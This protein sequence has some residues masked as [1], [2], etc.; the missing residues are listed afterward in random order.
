MVRLLPFMLLAAAAPAVAVSLGP[1]EKSGITDG[2][3][4][5]FYL[6][7]AN[8]YPTAERFVVEAVGVADETAQPRVTMFPRDTVLGRG[9]RRQ[10]LVIVN[11]L[12]PGERFAFRVCA[13]RSPKPQETIHARVCS[14]LAAR[15][16]APR[17]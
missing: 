13:M 3:G 16:L 15:R 17:A 8:P 6:T 7:L 11:D 10:L 9:S 4:K 14:K 5:A 2:P 1:L 12:A